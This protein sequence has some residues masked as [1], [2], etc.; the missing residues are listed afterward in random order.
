MQPL[1]CKLKTYCLLVMW[2]VK[3][4]VN[5]SYGKQFD[6]FYYVFQIKLIY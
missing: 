3:T 2:K 6:G 4:A 5:T 1:K